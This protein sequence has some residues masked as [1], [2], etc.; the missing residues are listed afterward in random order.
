MRFFPKSKEQALAEGY[1]W[2]DRLAKKGE[3]AP[4][5]IND[6]AIDCLRYCVFTH[7]IPTYQPYKDGHNAE[8]YQRG[9]FNPGSR[10]F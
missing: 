8:D 7:K 2:D 6:H 4:L 5:K 10:K 3:D 1:V 9:R